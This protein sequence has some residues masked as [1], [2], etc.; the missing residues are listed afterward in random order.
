MKS[1]RGAVFDL[2][3]ILEGDNC[4]RTVA[5]Q[6]A[7]A[8]ART[9]VAAPY[10][11]DVITTVVC[12]IQLCPSRLELVGDLTPEAAATKAD[13]MRWWTDGTRHICPTCKEL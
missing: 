13:G 4:A 10:M 1:H 11:G 8:E 2:L 3:R 6:V 12:N 5:E 7:I 9:L